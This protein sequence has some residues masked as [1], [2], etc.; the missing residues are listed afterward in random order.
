M[1][2]PPLPE[3]DGQVHGVVGR[4]SFGSHSAGAVAAAAA[5]AAHATR[6]DGD[7][8]SADEMV[9]TKSEPLSVTEEEH[10]ALL[11]RLHRSD[12]LIRQLKH[13]VKAQHSKIE[14]LR[15]RCEYA[16]GCI[17]SQMD[18]QDKV[19]VV[20]LKEDNDDFR[21]L[22]N[23]LRAE[24]AKVKGDN[25]TLRKANR[26]LKAMIVQE[27]TEGPFTGTSMMSTAGS[28]SMERSTLLDS[29]F[30]EFPLLP[31]TSRTESSGE[32]T[33]ASPPPSA[34]SGGS[35]PSSARGGKQGNSLPPF[36]KASRLV[37]SLPLFWRDLESSAS[38]LHALQ[39]V[40]ERLLSDRPSTV[41]TLYVV[42]PFVRS[43]ASALEAKSGSSPTLFYL[44]QG[45]TELQVFP[46]RRCSNRPEPPRFGDLQALPYRTRN[47]LAVAVQMPNSHRTL[48]ILQAACVAEDAQ[49]A[50][51]SVAKQVPSPRVLK[52]HCDLA[53]PVEPVGFTD[54]QLA[55]LQLVCSV[56][57]SSLYYIERLDNRAHMLE[58]QRACVEVAVAV[59]KARNLADFE[60][61]I[62]HLLGPFFGA[63]IV[64]VLFY[65]ADNQKLLMP[66]AQMR[67]KD[68][69]SLSIDKGV[70]GLCAKKKTVISVSNISQHPYVDAVADGLQRSGRP[71]AANSAMLCGPLHV[72]ADEGI[73]QGGLLGVVQLLER[74]K[75]LANSAMGSEF[76]SE[77]QSLF[78]Q[79]LQVF[80]HAGWRALKAQELQAKLEGAPAT[81]ARL[82]MG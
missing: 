30:K 25:D 34:R 16:E 46:P 55:Y 33:F 52:R 4:R 35:K 24:Q 79:L 78:Q 66:C 50:G 21:R 29:T 38:V 41:L 8:S 19:D 77:E 59:N 27:P 51:A 43:E 54:S 45:R 28:A 76:S 75:K 6:D 12:E 60:Q 14:E 74:K 5:A 69:Q 32:P 1:V 68:Y 13:I 80:A 37:S 7:N 47:A 72:E 31:N 22:V 65:D 58:R 67:R 3:D 36:P 56:A 9:A 73:D 70:V 62:K 57:A 42:D 26:R 61:R 23:K 64:R 10:Q 63:N 82:L 11:R 44:G 15:E 71:V 2:Q 48:A 17:K 18:E 49:G 39:E 20:Q 53:E 40:A 81:L